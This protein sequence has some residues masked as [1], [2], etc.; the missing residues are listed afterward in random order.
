MRLASQ[1]DMFTYVGSDI[2][3]VKMDHLTFFKI[4]HSLTSNEEK[5]RFDRIVEYDHKLASALFSYNQKD[6]NLLGEGYLINNNQ[7]LRSL[8]FASQLQTEFHALLKES[9][10]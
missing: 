3:E 1:Y 4:F 10:L 9:L 2:D 7:I 8:A 6:E 5:I